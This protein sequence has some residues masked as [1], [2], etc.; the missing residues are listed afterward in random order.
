MRELLI[1]GAGIV[2][3]SAKRIADEMGWKTTLVDANPKKA[4][5][6]AALATIRPQ[7]LGENGKQIAERSWRWYEKWGATVT[8][9]AIVSSYS[10]SESRRQQDWWLVD[11]DKVLI[12]PDV[13]AEIDGIWNDHSG[14]YANVNGDKCRYDAILIGVG[15]HDPRYLPPFKE[16]HG[17]T[18]INE[19][20][21]LAEPLYVHHL[22]PYHSLTIGCMN[23]VVRLGSSVANTEQKAIDEIYRMLEVAEQRGIVP[24]VSDWIL[25]TNIRAKAPTIKEPRRGERTTTIGNLGRSGYGY[26]PHLVATWLADLT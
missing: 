24:K 23:D 17:A 20:M 16:Q 26:A 1:V 7:W 19:T 15:A 14:Q 10:S 18:L 13:V 12:Q 8:R 9:T 4:A 2:G 11:P 21:R 5:S 6:R 3:S 25:T 22:R